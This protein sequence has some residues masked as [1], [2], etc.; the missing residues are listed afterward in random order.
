MPLR[1]LNLNRCPWLPA[2]ATPVD[3]VVDVDAVVV[4]VV[5]DA[6]LDVAVVVVVAVA[7]VVIVIAVA[8]A[9]AVVVVA[10]VVVAVAVVVAGVWTGND[11]APLSPPTGSIHPTVRSN[12]A[13]AR[14]GGYST[15]EF[16]VVF[17]STVTTPLLSAT[18]AWCKHD[19]RV[20]L[21][22]CH[23]DTRKPHG[24]S[25]RQLDAV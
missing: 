10:V 25:H 5:I 8:V 4:D 1:C 7:T 19:S 16:A 15:P 24:P 14:F 9:V 22:A 12:A 11:S 23:H 18:R 6:V 3:A 2:S 13:A 20:A 17:T 21:R